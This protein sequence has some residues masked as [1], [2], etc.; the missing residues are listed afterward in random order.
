MYVI[1]S[2]NVAVY[3]EDSVGCEIKVA[4][5]THEVALLAGV[6]GQVISIVVGG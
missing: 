1:V 4:F 6:V 5:P 2:E 3:D